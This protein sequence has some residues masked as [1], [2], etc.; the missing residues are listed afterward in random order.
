MA[1]TILV[2]ICH[3]RWESLVDRATECQLI[4]FLREIFYDFQNFSVCLRMVKCKQNLHLYIREVCLTKANG[5]SHN[6]GLKM[7]TVAKSL[8]GTIFLERF[9]SVIG[10]ES[11]G[12]G[13]LNFW[14]RSKYFGGSKDLLQRSY[15]YMYGHLRSMVILTSFDDILILLHNFRIIFHPVYFSVN[16]DSQRRVATLK[17][18]FIKS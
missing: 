2:T 12:T 6:S 8:L 14:W 11:R 5:T 1:E 10:R 7:F 3:S 13:N 16:V 4:I 15:S 9:S 17:I 18:N